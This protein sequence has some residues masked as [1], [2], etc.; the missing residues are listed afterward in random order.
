M[1]LSLGMCSTEKRK[2]SAN[3]MILANL[4]RKCVPPIFIT[5]ISYMINL[6]GRL[7]ITNSYFWVHN[8]T[9]LYK[10]KMLRLS[11][12][13]AWSFIWIQSD[14][15]SALQVKDN[16]LEMKINRTHNWG[17]HFFIIMSLNNWHYF[18]LGASWVQSTVLNVSGEGLGLFCLSTGRNFP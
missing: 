13:F 5:Y 17:A 12:L 15:N 3:S 14:L 11:I 6:F 16:C 1:Y 2:T 7:E 9:L 4:G 18:I 8:K 10:V